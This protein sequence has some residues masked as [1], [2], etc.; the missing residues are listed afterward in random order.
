MFNFENIKKIFNYKGETYKNIV[1]QDNKNVLDEDSYKNILNG[2]ILRIITTVVGQIILIAIAVVVF[3]KTYSW[4]YGSNIVSYAISETLKSGLLGY[5]FTIILLSA[6]PIASIIFI[7]VTKKQEQ[8]TW[9]YFILLILVGLETIYSLYRTITYFVWMFSS[10]ILSLLGLACVFF[11]LLANVHVAVGCIDFC[12]NTNKKT[13]QVNST[14][15]QQTSVQSQI[16]QTNNVEPIQV[17]TTTPNETPQPVNNEP[18][19][20]TNGIDNDPNKL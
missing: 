2:S 6:V 3:T 20:N 5:I 11:A 10:P 14:T 17:T 1:P 15:N 19:N 16:T 13:S 12:Y 8:T 7:H 9:P 4:L 18:T